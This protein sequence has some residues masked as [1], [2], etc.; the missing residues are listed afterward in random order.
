MRG[1]AVFG[2]SLDR[3]ATPAVTSLSPS[4]SWFWIAFLFIYAFGLDCRRVSTLYFDPFFN[5]LYFMYIQV[6]GY[7]TCTSMPITY[8]N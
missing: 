1:G 8:Y 7:I 5:K 4:L 3:V 6:E 2:W